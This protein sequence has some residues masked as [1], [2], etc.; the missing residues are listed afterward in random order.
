M[1]EL[2]YQ[3]SLLI[4]LAFSPFYLKFLTYMAR[5]GW[6]RA[7]WESDR[8]YFPPHPKKRKTDGES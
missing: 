1:S 5:K 2:G 6:L 8:L 3:I 4:L 7:E